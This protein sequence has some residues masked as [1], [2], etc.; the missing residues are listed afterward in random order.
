MCM[1]H[2]QE[3]LRLVGAG[4]WSM[5]TE[6]ERYRRLRGGLGVMQRSLIRYVSPIAHVRDL[7]ELLPPPRLTLEGLLA[8]SPG[9]GL[10][11]LEP[12]GFIGKY[13]I[14]T[15]SSAG[16]IAHAAYGLNVPKKLGVVYHHLPDFNAILEYM[17]SSLMCS[18]E[19]PLLPWCYASREKMF[20]W[21]M[22]TRWWMGVRLVHRRTPS[23]T[24][25]FVFTLFPLDEGVKRCEREGGWD[26]DRDKEKF[27]RVAG[28]AWRFV[29]VRICVYKRLVRA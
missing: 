6:A 8:L 2:V 22:W 26:A 11:Y 16:A 7:D 4:A 9:E 10:R 24:L 23:A 21:M 25:P 20:I 14:P 19:I 29:K 17:Q 5:A 3:A 28:V 1:L 27:P 15:D 13:R 12:K 18:S